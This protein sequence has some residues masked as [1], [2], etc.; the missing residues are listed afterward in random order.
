[1][2]RIA[3]LLLATAVGLLALAGQG[4]VTTTAVVSQVFVDDDPSSCAPGGG[5]PNYSTIKDALAAVSGNASI[6]VCEGV[7]EEPNIKIDKNGT[8]VIGPGAVPNGVGVAT[9]KKAD[10][11]SSSF[12]EITGN[13]SSLAGF[14]IDAARPPGFNFQL[15]PINVTGDHDSVTDNVIHDAD[16]QPAISVF[17]TSDTISRNTISNS[18]AGI[19]CDGCPS[20]LFKDNVV[21]GPFSQSLGIQVTGGGVT[22]QDNQVNGGPLSVHGNGAMVSGNTVDDAG[23][24]D[25]TVRLAG[26]PI[27]FTQNTIMNTTGVGMSITENG[28][29]ST[30]ATIT[31]NQLTG[32]MG[33]AVHV[34]END[35]N[36]AITIT[37]TFGGALGGGN[38]I[39]GSPYTLVYYYATNNM[40]AEFNTWGFC[41]SQEIADRINDGDES[42]GVGTVDFEPFNPV[43]CPSIT[44]TPSATAAPTPTPTASPSGSATSSPSPV[45]T[46]AGVLKRGDVNC[47]GLVQP[48]DALE[49]VVFAA[50][51][52]VLHSGCPDIGGSAFIVG[53]GEITWAD[54]DCDGDADLDDALQ[55]LAYLGGTHEGVCSPGADLGDVVPGP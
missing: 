17:G 25:Y 4:A 7:Y 21:N 48:D 47:N 49:L 30:V 33:E 40:D 31:K 35:V 12:I 53:G 28:L 36:D 41:T 20:S 9:I 32:M 38:T 51:V 5:P 23:G 50:N 42:G 24:G 54:E 16:I 14:D 18:V 45:V 39:S 44:P 27:T 26:N 34:Q 15:T 55:L 3:L 43:N 22:V 52:P 19:Y 1:M 11:G 13:S 2:S 6:T 37:A 29:A 46:P 10:N 8:A